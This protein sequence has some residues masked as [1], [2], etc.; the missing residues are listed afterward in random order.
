MEKIFPFEQLFSLVSGIPFIGD[1][2]DAIFSFLSGIPVIG[3]VVD[4]IFM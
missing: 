3:G 1:I 4:F 2:A